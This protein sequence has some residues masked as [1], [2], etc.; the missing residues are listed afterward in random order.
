MRFL[1]VLLATTVLAQTPPGR[2]QFEA[3]C[4]VCH[5][6]RGNGG[7]LGPAI[8]E[9]LR[10]YSDAELAALI[11]EGLPNS[12]MPANNLS[13]GDT[14]SLIEY[15][16]TLRDSEGAIARSVKV[17]LADGRA[18]EG[19]V[20]NQSST[21]MQLLDTGGRLHLLRASGK[22][23]RQVSSDT[24]WPTY[25]GQFGG[26]RYTALDQ[27]NKSNLSR[28]APRWIFTLMNTARLQVTP[29]VVEGVM[30]VTSAN[31]CYAL[32][33]GSGREIWHYQR[34]RTKDLVGNAAGGINR[35][36]AVL[37]GR[38]FMATDNAHL[39]ALNRFTGRLLWETEM[40]D[41]H[42]NYNATSAPLTV[43]N[44]V[45]SGTAGGD[46]GARGFVAAFDQST[47]R[48][49]WRFWTVP[50]RGEPGSET[51]Q[52]DDI[53]HPSAATWLT[54]TYDPQL[55]TI[56]W[57]TGNP[58][59]DLNGDERGGDNLYSS[60]IVA[61]DAK[62]GKMKWYF[63]YTPHNVW[64]WDAEQP[65]VLVDT[66]WNGRPRKLLLHA[67]RNGF[68]YV[69]DRT[70]GKLLLAKPFVHK[71]T[72]AR[73]VDEKGRPLL[74]PNQEPTEEGNRICPSLEGATNWFS[75]SFNPATHLY[76]VQTL[77]KCDL[78]TKSKAPW[79]AGS[80]YFGGSFEQAP[81]DTAQKV[82]RAIRID[83][84]SIAWELPQVGPG[85]SW[86]GTLATSTGLVF[87][88]ED[89]GAF[90]AADA[91]TGKPLWQFQANQLWKASP[92]TYRFDGK[93]YLAVASGSSI[94]SFA[95]MD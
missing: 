45:I 34:R 54:G 70:D 56:Y 89:S 24:D 31:E 9:R 43:G 28:L 55:D 94:L 20:M 52:G 14:Q 10:H 78:F 63:Q 36:A 67:N 73:G 77:E 19:R 82:L 65:P 51:W 47:G 95:L 72:W 84:G 17:T 58:G 93:Q 2:A 68:F 66:T 37:G 75:T 38:L 13:A 57:P 3:H 18:L 60:S 33:A 81:G 83:D 11:H 74:N 7:E 16:R 69:L 26:N 76:Y 87:F 71:L 46:E 39:I 21:D 8:A 80:G 6:R 1:P 32:D 92:M 91:A 12:G 22:V 50:K 59:P 41:W 15:L 53:D 48:E 35:G 79:K 25:N 42:L 86:G 44:L 40:A 61:L 62:S 5:G 88:C 4:S 85:N 30:Y 27:I 90:M 49:V 23:Y 64:D 29:I